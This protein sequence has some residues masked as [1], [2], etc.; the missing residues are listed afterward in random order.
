MKTFSCCKIKNSGFAWLSHTIMFYFPLS[1]RSKVQEGVACKEMMCSILVILREPGA[2]SPLIDASLWFF[3]RRGW[4]CHKLVREGWKSYP[5]MNF[6]H[7]VLSCMR[8]QDC[9]W[10]RV[11]KIRLAN[12][13]E[14]S[15]NAKT[16]VAPLFTWFLLC[17]IMAICTWL[18]QNVS[19][20]KGR[21]PEQRPALS[22]VHYPF[23]SVT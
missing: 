19:C 21:D 3:F 11:T 6:A 14:G 9:P 22:S 10:R 1:V 20:L 18:S 15:K 16:L 23:P 12:L 8:N 7:N 17:L 5:P 2:V 4:L 13:T